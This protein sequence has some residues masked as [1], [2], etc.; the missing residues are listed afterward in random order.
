[1]P[2]TVDALVIT[3]IDA[4]LHRTDKPALADYLRGK[5]VGIKTWDLLTTPG[6]ARDLV[7]PG[8]GTR[9]DALLHAVKL[10][11]DAHGV[12]NIF[13]VNHSACAAYGSTE[14]FGDAT[15]EYRTHADDLRAAREVLRQFLPNLDVRLFFATVEERVDGPFVTIDEVR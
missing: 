9:K 11:H 12:T 3:C 10:A 4:S 6:G 1:M 2:A 7:A 13:L 5:R 14:H 8:A 15:K